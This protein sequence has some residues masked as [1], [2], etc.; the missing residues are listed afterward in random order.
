MLS[1]IGFGGYTTHLGRGFGTWAT[2]VPVPTR[3]PTVLE[4][5]SSRP[6][7]V[8]VTVRR[9]PRRSSV[10]VELGLLDQRH[11]AVLEVLNGATVTDVARR[12]GVVRQTLNDWPVATRSTRSRGS[13]TEAPSRPPA[14]IRCHPRSRPGSVR[15]A[16]TT[17]AEDPSTFATSSP[18]S[19][20]PWSRADRRSTGHWCATAFSSPPSAGASEATT[21]VG[22]APAPWS[23]GRW[24][25][26]PA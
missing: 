23:C 17:L 6:L 20:S 4:V 7:A 24:T 5:S 8:D 14:R 19:R 9:R 12:Y 1:Q 25:W 22:S 21:S 13:A 26:S 15:S 18:R 11:Q 16:G 10:L 2:V 3:H